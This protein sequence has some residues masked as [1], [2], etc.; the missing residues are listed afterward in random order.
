MKPPVKFQWRGVHH[1]YLGIFFTIFGAF[2]LYMN[3][4]N[5]WGFL[6]YIYSFFVIAGIYLIIDDIVE[7]TITES[8][9]MRILWFKIILRE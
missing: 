3:A 2:F 5:T 8:T 9:P 4:V 6:N 7:H 1:S